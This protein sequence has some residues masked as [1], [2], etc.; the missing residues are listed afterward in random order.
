VVSANHPESGRVTEGVWVLAAP[1]LAAEVLEGRCESLRATNRRASISSLVGA[2]LFQC[3]GAQRWYKM[4]GQT[5]GIVTALVS[6]CV[7]AVPIRA[8][9]EKRSVIL[10]YICRDN[11]EYVA[12]TPT[13]SAANVLSVLHAMACARS[14][15]H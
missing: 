2:D 8:R 11:P 9:S 15:R 10:V 1:T 13:S 7:P 14:E 12:T 5:V 3:D 6:C 4:C